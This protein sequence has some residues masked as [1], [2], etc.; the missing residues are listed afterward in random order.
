MFINRSVGNKRSENK[1]T[2][3]K[4]T[5]KIRNIKQSARVLCTAADSDVTATIKKSDVFNSS[6]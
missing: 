5:H 3:K 2:N 1:R 6:L 4:S